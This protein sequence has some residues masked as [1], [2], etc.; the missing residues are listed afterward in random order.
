[1]P[2]EDISAV[3]DGDEL[4]PNGSSGEPTED[5]GLLSSDIGF[6]HA[7]AASF[8]VIIVSEL[9]DKTFFI[10]AI[11]AMRHPRLTVFAGAIAALALMTVLSVVFGMAAT[12]IPR[13]YTF[14]ISTALFA[15]FGLKMLKDGYYMSATEAAEELEEVQSDLRKR[16]DELT[17]SLSGQRKETVELV[18]L[19]ETEDLETSGKQRMLSRNGTAIVIGGAHQRT[20]TGGSIHSL[21]ELHGSTGAA[22]ASAASSSSSLRLSSSASQLYAGNNRSGSA[23]AAVPSLVDGATGHQQSSQQ[24]LA[25]RKPANGISTVGEGETGVL[26]STIEGG[27]GD[28]GGNDADGG[29]GVGVNRG[30]AGGQQEVILETKRNGTGGESEQRQRVR[31]NAANGSIATGT[32]GTTVAG[33]KMLEREVSA[34]GSLMKVQDAESGTNRRSSRP[35]NVALKMLFRIFAQ[36]FTM[37]F[38]AEW[39]DRSQLT[40]IILSARENVYGVIAGGVIGHSICTGLAVIGG[41]MIAQRISVR[42]VTLIGGVVF[43]LFAVSALFFGPGEEEPAKVPIP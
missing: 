4:A 41:R 42:T 25:G 21:V 28:G 31:A 2:K 32:D 26:Q 22:A 38:L 33:S 36:A 30:T 19:S 18:P 6:V 13:V 39:G 40:T 20:T 3:S 43:L 16:D 29:G 27:L 9:G 15:L 24:R 12:I 17:R 7:F 14:Y 10:A 5:K 1:M 11:M 35:H 34:S 8:M 37:T 23:V